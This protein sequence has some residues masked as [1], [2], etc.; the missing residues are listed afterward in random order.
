M[1]C[2]WIAATVVLW[3]ILP[4]RSNAYIAS[5]NQSKAEEHP[6]Q[7]TQSS[8][9][10]SV[11]QASVTTQEPSVA[12]KTAAKEPAVKSAAAQ[13]T[14]YMLVELSKTL[15]ANKLKPGDKITARVSQDVVSHGKVIVPEETEV[16]GHV[17]EVRARDGENSESRLG[18][19]FDEI[20]LKHF[21]DISVQAV[22]QS[23]AA[24]V[25][26]RSRIDEPSQ[27]LPPNSNASRIQISNN[28]PAASQSAANGSPSF[29][30]PLTVKQ[31][32]SGNAA[33]GA[34]AAE[35]NAGA[36]G[37][38]LSVGTPQG[39]IG[40]KGLSLSSA[41]SADTPGPVIVSNTGNVKL[42]YG[43]QIL[44]H[45]LSVESPK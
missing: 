45:V 15:K 16:V 39:V 7:Q 24:P 43:T 22:V 12:P 4:C 26:R 25:V 41:P 21:H 8:S 29:T 33:S 30:T 11:S 27:M 40:I 3:A 38:S 20:L 17:T 44:L 5:P 32:P 19:V 28:P 13:P 34:S 23:V 1:K 2:C 6:A 31:S 14:A 10:S 42:E 9:P 35:L 37:S 36:G 18:I